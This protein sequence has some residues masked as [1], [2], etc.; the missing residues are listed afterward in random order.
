M[1]VETTKISCPEFLNEIK[2]ISKDLGRWKPT[3]VKIHFILFN[4]RNR[5]YFDTVASKANPLDLS[6]KVFSVLTEKTSEHLSEPTPTEITA[7]LDI[8]SKMESGQFIW[9]KTKMKKDTRLCLIT[10]RYGPFQTQQFLEHYKK[11][12]SYLGQETLTLLDEEDEFIISEE[13]SFSSWCCIGCSQKR[14]DVSQGKKHEP[15]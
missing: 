2:Q 12:Q 6:K 15:I 11:E 7:H 5:L 3:S 8:F 9:F 10:D 1:T 4:D 13:S 14:D